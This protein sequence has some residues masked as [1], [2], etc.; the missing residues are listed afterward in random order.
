MLTATVT[1]STGPVLLSGAVTFTNNGGPIPECPTAKPVTP[2]TGVASCM[3][4]SLIAGSHTIGAAYG[5]DPNFTGSSATAAQSVQDYALALMTSGPITITQGY[6][7]ST[8]PFAKE[9][10]TAT[11]SSI[12]NFSGTLALTCNVVAVSVPSGAVL[13]Q[14]TLSNTSLPIPTGNTVNVTINAGS[15]SSAASPGAYTVSI[16]GVDATTGLSHTTSPIPFNIQFEAAPLT[17]V[18]GAT[19][20]NTTT[21]EFVLPANV[22]ITGFQCASVTGPTLASSVAPVALSIGCA[23]NPAS[24]APSGSAQ[25]ASVTITI[26]TG[27]AT[28][29]KLNDTSN[30]TTIVVAGV[31]GIP[32]LALFGFMPGG[33]TSRKIF[34]RYLGIVFALVVLLQGVGCGGGSFTAPKSVSGQTPPGAYTILVQGTGTDGQTYQA[35]IQVNV[36][37]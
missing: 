37:R 10:I 4:T 23:F 17:I 15:G 34:L 3:T 33:K 21:A 35:V 6:T 32:I 7:N 1:P 27:G 20:G 13:P 36:T 22:G 5:S 2:S 12:A 11:A 26:S 19:T 24:V 30:R 16:T 28:T 31:L 14:C 18:S 29:A 25:T 8:D 9:S